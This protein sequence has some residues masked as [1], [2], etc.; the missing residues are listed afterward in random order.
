[1]PWRPRSPLEIEANAVGRDIGVPE[2]RRND[3]DDFERSEEYA[4][5]AGTEDEEV[6][7]LV[8][9]GTAATPRPALD[10]LVTQGR[11]AIRQ[12]DRDGLL[13]VA[14]AMLEAE[15]ETPSELDA[16][17]YR[18]ELRRLIA[19]EQL[20]MI[21]GFAHGDR[22]QEAITL[23]RRF[24][25]EA[26]EVLMVLLVEA[27]TISE[28]RGYYA[29][30]S[31]ISHGTDAVIAR[32]SHPQWYVVRNA[33]DLC[34]GMTLDAAVPDLVRQCHH[35]DERVR[36]AVAEAL[37]RIGT[38]GARE[39]LRKMLYDPAAAVRMKALAHLNG[40]QARGMSSAIGKL[41]LREDLE[42]VQFE[43]LLALGRIGS[44]D[45]VALL[46]EWAA[47]GGKL[48]GRKPVA[49]RL[50]A[51]RGLVL[52]GP[53]ALGALTTLQRDDDPE[54]RQAASKAIDALNP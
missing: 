10:L 3:A 43:A 46:G 27:A 4:S 5:S 7:P 31:Q 40:R 16:S 41:L 19:H 23:L 39:G 21:A 51:L 48:L 54:V 26:S 52:A 14:L 17:T 50:A 12:D 45:A 6:P 42:M 35:E 38:P 34:G 2:I 22:R 13:D 37:G 8:S 20:V 24:G 36:K 53:T 29:A 47:P 33:A 18:I 1:M 49:S 25:T 28:R 15:N 9:G 11:E 30:I 32:L 44:P